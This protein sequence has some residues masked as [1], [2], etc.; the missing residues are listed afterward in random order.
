M[1]LQKQNFLY[2]SAFIIF[3]GTLLSLI[4]LTRPV[5]VVMINY[6]TSLKNLDANQRRNVCLA[7]EK[8]NG[9]YIKPNAEFSFNRVVGPRNIQNGFTTAKVYFE[10]DTFEDVGGGICFISSA[11]YNAALNA[12]F[13]ITRRV[14]HSMPISSFPMGLDATVWYGY[15]DL[16]FLNNTAKNIRIDSKCSYNNLDIVIRGYYKP[17]IVKI[18][19]IK[20]KESKDQIKVITR[21]KTPF[22]SEKISDDTYYIY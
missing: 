7:A 9:T 17:E 16:E 5:P 14:A 4:Y 8:I 20:I 15:G 22:N 12:N 10:K 18:T 2:L 11:L 6:S 1:K 13:K 21:R 3:I 19:T